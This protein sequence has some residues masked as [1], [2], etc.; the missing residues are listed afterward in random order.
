MVQGVSKPDPERVASKSAVQQVKAMMREV[1]EHGTGA[2]A[3]LENYSVAG[4]TGTGHLVGD[5]GYED[6]RYSSLFA[7]FAPADDPKLVI[8]VVINDPKGEDYF[9]GLV[10]AP[11]FSEVMGNAL[12]ALNV[13]GDQEGVLLGANP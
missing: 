1:V 4:K 6:H 12:R 3:A 13:P 5:F 11:V 2:L 7:G 9:G 8:A 10:A